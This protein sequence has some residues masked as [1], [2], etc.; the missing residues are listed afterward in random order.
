MGIA[1]LVVAMA[2]TLDPA[3]GGSFFYYLNW[4]WIFI[5]VTIFALL[6][7][8]TGIFVIGSYHP[9]KKKSFNWLAYAILSKFSN[10]CKSIE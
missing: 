5:I 7:F 2:P 3:F 8:I 6:V 1:G 9:V 10:R 4:R